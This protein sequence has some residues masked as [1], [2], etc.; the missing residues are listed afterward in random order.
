MTEHIG[1]RLRWRC[2]RGMKELDILF[3]RFLKSRFETMD[4][5][6]KAVFLDFLNLPDPQ[7]TDYLLRGLVPADAA[8]KTLVEQILTCPHD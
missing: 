2:R 6:Q 3:E 4:G 8:F 1:A 7:L 5:K